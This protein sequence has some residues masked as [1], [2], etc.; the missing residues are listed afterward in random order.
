MGRQFSLLAVPLREGYNYVVGTARLRQNRVELGA[1]D[2]ESDFAAVFTNCYARYSTSRVE[3]GLH[4]SA[5]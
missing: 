3:E 2:I 5:G 4:T 1:C